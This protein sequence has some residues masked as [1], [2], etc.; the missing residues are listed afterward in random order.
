MK[1]F[2]V[3]VTNHLNIT[4]FQ[5]Q[6]QTKFISDVGPRRNLILSTV[7]TRLLPLVLLCLF[8]ERSG[9]E[10]WFQRT[11]TDDV[12][13]GMYVLQHSVCSFKRRLSDCCHSLLVLMWERWFSQREMETVNQ[14]RLLN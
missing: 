7:L 13:S 3:L 8:Q 11:A 2:Q 1:R 5:L 4:H 14:S 10:K 6:H 12:K 9:K